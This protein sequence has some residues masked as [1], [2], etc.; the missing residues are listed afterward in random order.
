M[1]YLDSALLG[2][3][4]LSLSTTLFYA[5]ITVAYIPASP[6]FIPNTTFPFS[7]LTAHTTT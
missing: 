2:P 5:P 1:K 6:P 3:C 7:F 4:S